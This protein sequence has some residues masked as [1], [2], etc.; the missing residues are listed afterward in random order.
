MSNASTLVPNLSEEVER[1]PATHH[2]LR[3]LRDVNEDE[4]NEDNTKGDEG[5]LGERSRDSI[6]MNFERSN[7]WESRERR[8]KRNRKSKLRMV[9]KWMQKYLSFRSYSVKSSMAL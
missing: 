7:T 9:V 3:R 5:S 6:A 2:F 8:S 4:D 1:R